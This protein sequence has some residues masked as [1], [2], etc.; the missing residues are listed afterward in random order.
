MTLQKSSNLGLIKFIA[1]LLVIVSHA[2][3]LSVSGGLDPLE[4]VTRQRLTLGGFAVAIFFF[5]SGL[6]VTKS[7]FKKPYFVPYF[8]QRIIRIFPPLIFVALITVFILGTLITKLS[9]TDYFTNS[10]TYKYLLNGICILQHDLPGV[11]E[12]NVYGSVV[13]GALWTMPVEF[14]LYIVCFIG[15][16]I[17]LLSKKPFVVITCIAFAGWC[18]LSFTANPMVQASYRACLMFCFGMMAYLIKDKIR[19]D[20]RYAIIALVAIIISLFTPV[21]S[22]VF[23]VAFPYILM[24]LSW[25]A[26]QIPEKIGNL[27]NLSYGVYLCAFPIQQTVVY[28]NGGSMNPYGNMLISLPC[29]IAVGLAVY[30]IAEKM[31]DRAINKKK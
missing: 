17:K 23:V 10:M 19:L 7:L 8:K 21:F 1:A 11:F 6:L 27:G 4:I 16:K 24:Y 12:G 31:F 26:P 28:L 3:P 14:V 25:K 5:A 18:Y 2:F 9:L 15:Y 20:G 22:L 30:L 29:A 13:N